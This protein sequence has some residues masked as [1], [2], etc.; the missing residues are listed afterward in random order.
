[1]EF[2]VTGIFEDIPENSHIKF[3]IVLPW[4][5]LL[6]L[7]GADYEDSWGDSGAFTYILF[8]EGTDIGAFRKK[9]DEIADKEFGEALRYYKLTLHL[10]LQPLADIHLSSHYQQEYEVNGDRTVVSLL[11][12]IAL[13]II[14]IAWVNYIN[15]STARSLTRAKEVGLRKVV[16]A[17]RSQLMQQFFM[18]TILINLFAVL[19]TL[20]LL[21]FLL[22]YFSALTGTPLN[23][24]LW[25]QKWFWPVMVFLLMAGV[26]LSGFYPVALLSSFRPMQVLKGNPGNSPKGL[27]LRKVLVVFQFTMS[28]CLLTFTFAVFRQISFL[29]SQPLGFAIDQ[30]FVVRAPR[31]RDEAFPG[32]V[33]VFKQELL[34]QTGISDMCV[35]TEVPGRQIYWDAGGIHP[36]G[37]DES[38]NYQI[39]GIDYDFVDLFQTTLLAGRNFSTQFPSDTLA[40]ILNETAVKVTW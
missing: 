19:L 23:Y 15:L 5:S 7:L 18:E 22:P 28:L 11:L 14:G 21:K 38:K 31:V 16:G 39:V 26:F 35:V 9:L 37:S 33:K 25:H 4:A 13:L 30:V 24:S 2:R 10:P 6:D 12:A 29:K 40:L 34:K 32:K 1:M 36:V 27:N 20:L 3:D 17:S 8:R